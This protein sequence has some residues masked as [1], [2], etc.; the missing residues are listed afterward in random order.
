MFME[1]FVGLSFGKYL[2]ERLL[3]VRHAN[4]EALKNYRNYYSEQ[5][6]QVDELNEDFKLFEIT[7][8]IRA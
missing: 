6:L 4:D 5:A 8:M 2:K 7:T 3:A 1:Q